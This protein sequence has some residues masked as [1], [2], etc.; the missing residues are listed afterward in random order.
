MTFPANP[1]EETLMAFRIGQVDG[2]VFLRALAGAEV[3]VPLPSGAGDD[4]QAA[5]P[6]M[7]IEDAR[8][9]AVYTSEEQCKKGAGQMTY[10]VTPGGA[11]VRTLPPGLGLAVNPGGDVGLP[12]H[13]AGMHV[14]RGEGS[15]VEAGTQIMLGEPAE[16]P[17]A[18]LESLRIAF[19]GT[20]EVTNARRAWAVIGAEGSLII[21]VAL[22]PD[23]PQTRQ[24]ALD[25]VNTAIRETVVPY[26]VD[27]VFLSDPADPLAAWLLD[28]TAPFYVR[29]A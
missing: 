29:S 27:T 7:M 6:I 4:G 1:L 13:A 18:F 2:D 24:T 17:V 5:L 20:R 16:E 23:T 3:W 10:A 22:A 25:A 14:L 28:N 8:Y 15:T 26:G 11:F 21:G 9:V 12:I 19:A